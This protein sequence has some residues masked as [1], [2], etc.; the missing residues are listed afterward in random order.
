EVLRQPWPWLAAAIA[1]AIWL[2]NLAW[3]AEHGFPQVTMAQSIAVDQ[4]TGVG[5]RLK[6][7]VEILAIAGPFL[8][9]VSVA[10]AIWLVRAR[11]A[12]PWRPLGLGFLLVVGLMLV[13]NGKSYYSAGYLP[14]AIAAGAIPLAGWLDHGRRAVRRGVFAA[15]TIV[16]GVTVALVMLPL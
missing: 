5:G 10:G 12:Q 13:V 14:L 1:A 2:P 4:G 7:I 6:S 3:Q 16:S 9:P 8:W 11:G 15:A